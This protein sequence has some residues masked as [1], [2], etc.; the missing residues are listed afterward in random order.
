M[1]TE[2]RSADFVEYEAEKA[3]PRLTSGRTT[4]AESLPTYIRTLVAVIFAYFPIIFKC[5]RETTMTRVG[6]TVWVNS[7]FCLIFDEILVLD[8]NSPF[9]VRNLGERFLIL[10]I[11]PFRNSR[12]RL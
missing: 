12:P 6:R 2:S 7:T 11:E 3:C 4:I 10:V 9:F 1:C 5:S 8:G